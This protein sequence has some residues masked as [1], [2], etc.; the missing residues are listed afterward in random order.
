MEE[1]G[2]GEGGGEGRGKRYL[3]SLIRIIVQ[4]EFSVLIIS[5]QFRKSI[6]AFYFIDF[7][8]G[9]SLI[10]TKAAEGGVL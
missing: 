3:H 9:G 1:G 5:F 7:G 4:Q 2:E 10:S 8:G 6:N